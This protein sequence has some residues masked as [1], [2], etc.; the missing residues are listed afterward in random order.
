MNLTFLRQR[1][2]RHLELRFF[3]PKEYE[4]S[5]LLQMQCR[6]YGSSSAGP[7]L[8]PHPRTTHA[9]TSMRRSQPSAPPS[10]A[11]CPRPV[12]AQ[13]CRQPAPPQH[14]I[15]TSQS[16]NRSMYSMVGVARSA[17][18]KTSHVTRESAVLWRCRGDAVADPCTDLCMHACMYERA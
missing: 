18:E 9:T 7:P 16:P 3:I 13:R 12:L 5:A 15:R 2:E 14:S 6:L 8:P 17:S 10:P 4:T 11:P 1:A